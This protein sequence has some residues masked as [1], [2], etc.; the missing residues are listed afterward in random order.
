V[1]IINAQEELNE[2]TLEW[3]STMREDKE[4]AKKKFN[5]AA[6]DVGAKVMAYNP[7]AKVRLFTNI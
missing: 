6:F 7:E 1:C 2:K 3:I 5:F 4:P